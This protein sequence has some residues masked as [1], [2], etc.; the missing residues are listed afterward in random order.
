MKVLRYLFP[1]DLKHV[2]LSLLT[3]RGISVTLMG[4]TVLVG[5]S[6]NSGQIYLAQL[7]SHLL[8]TKNQ[9]IHIGQIN[10][11]NF[12]GAEVTELVIK[13]NKKKNISADFIS[14]SWNIGFSP[15][16]KLK[17][18]DIKIG[19][20]EINRLPK[21]ENQVK[22]NQPVTSTPTPDTI[23]VL[24]SK[25][26]INHPKIPKIGRMTDYDVAFNIHTENNFSF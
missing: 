6:T 18:K 22:K 23:H 26:T 4:S 25:I 11:L 3:V 5:L 1:N 15:L 8:S 7:T 17:I 10:S 16:P 12:A 21:T 20:L 13:N 14:V 2:L 24:D 9:N 19:T